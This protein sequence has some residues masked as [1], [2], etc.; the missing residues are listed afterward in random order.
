MGA[1]TLKKGFINFEKFEHSSIR[2][3]LWH[4]SLELNL[5]FDI[6]TFR[7]TLPMTTWYKNPLRLPTSSNYSPSQML[8]C[9]I[10]SQIKARKFLKKVVT[11][12]LGA[13]LSEKLLLLVNIWYIGLE[14]IQWIVYKV[15][16]KIFIFKSKN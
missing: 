3:I 12:K 11:I 9:S 4:L 16:N 6:L 15:L 7:C 10:L 14:C 5:T 13:F 1:N 8:S 2:T